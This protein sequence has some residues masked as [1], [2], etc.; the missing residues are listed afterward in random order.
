MT[1]YL[2]ELRNCKLCEW[3]CGVDRLEGELGVCKM[4]KPRVASATLHPAPPESYTIFTQG[5]NFKCLNCQNWKIA[6]YP[7]SG[8]R[9]GDFLRPQKLAEE[10]YNRLNSAKGKSLGA[11]RV[12]FSGGSPG[13]SLP[14]VEKIVEEARKI[15][16]TKVNFDTNGFLTKESMKRVLEFTTS[17]TFDIKA[18][19]DEVHRAVTGAPV[20]PV[21][22]N[23][24]YV[25]E[26]ARDKLWEFRTLIIPGVT[27]DEVGPL[28][29]FLAEIDPS[30]PLNFL[31]FRPNFLMHG[32]RGA[33]RE[34]MEYAVEKAESAG[35]ENVSWSGLTGLPGKI[36]SGRSTNYETT[37]GQIA[38]RIAEESGCTT[39]PR[40]CGSCES[41]HD[42]T[43]KKYRPETVY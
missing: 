41:K 29:E 42:C 23:A 25:A 7:D 24:E 5:C 28:A 35:L 9:K 37:G 4:G 30:L 2:S 13:V 19:R 8:D 17:V 22:R 15:G 1:D 16:E 10:A 39:H 27:E 43:I 40:D 11:D 32:Y 18:Y 33:S 21:L 3:K 20:E 38:G 6:H 34:A 14:Y 36:P 26:H 12:F 31:A